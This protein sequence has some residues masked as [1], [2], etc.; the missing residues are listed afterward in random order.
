VEGNTITGALGSPEQGLKIIVVTPQPGQTKIYDVQV[1][2]GFAGALYD[3]TAAQLDPVSGTF[4]VKSSQFDLTI[5]S[6][7]KQIKLQQDRLT[8]KEERLRAQYTRMETALAKLEGFRSAF[9]AMISSVESNMNNSN[10]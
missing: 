1:K 6:L 2:Q 5:S 8:K 4:E 3:T 7:D 9:T 10:N